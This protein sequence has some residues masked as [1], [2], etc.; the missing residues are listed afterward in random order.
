MKLSTLE[1]RLAAYYDSR[2]SIHLVSSP[3]RGKSSLVSKAPDIIGRATGKNLGI[4]VVNAAMLTPMDLMGYGVPKH[5][6]GRSEMV[7]TDPFFWRTDEGKR[8]EEYDGGIVFFDEADKADTDVKKIMGEGAL[9][10]RF[11]PHRLPEGWVVWTAGNLASDRSGSTK[12]LDHLIN[13][14]MQIAVTDDLMS[15]LGWMDKNNVLPITQAFTQQHPDIVFTPGVPEK[16]APWA[17]PRSVVLADRHLQSLAKIEGHVPDDPDTQEEIAGIIGQG[18][19]AT[20]F[21]FIKLGREMPRFEDI[22]AEPMSTRVPGEHAPDA[23]MLVC[24]QLA[25][26]VCKD[27][28][29]A[30]VRYV[31]RMPDSFAVTFVRAAVTRNALLA[32]TPAIMNWTQR[33]AALMNLMHTLNKR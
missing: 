31:E 21:S 29:D 8:L 26:R 16:Q 1:R 22:V 4:V 23:R 27:T 33:N 3:G 15:L 13:R 9:S 19:A 14:R 2:I 18:A 20:L 5:D 7:F 6:N 17:T 32:V 10:G 25:H 24:Y 28:A 12:E 11:G 30:V